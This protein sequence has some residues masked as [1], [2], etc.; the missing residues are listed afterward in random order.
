MLS[1]RLHLRRRTHNKLRR[2][3]PTQQTTVTFSAVDEDETEEEEDL[4]EDAA[5]HRMTRR[6]G[7]DATASTGAATAVEDS[8]A[9]G[10]PTAAAQVIARACMP[11]S[12]CSFYP[13]S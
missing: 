4:E 13:G 1:A 7:K 10:R 12:R 5:L 8:S 11:S 6:S 3:R 2:H 9:S